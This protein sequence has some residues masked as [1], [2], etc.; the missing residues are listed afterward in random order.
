MS[1]ELSQ[2]AQ[3]V[4]DACMNASCEK[5][6]KTWVAAALCAAACHIYDELYYGRL[7]KER[8]LAIA[9]ELDGNYPEKPDSSIDGNSKDKLTSYHL[10]PISF[11]DRLPGS[12]DCDNE[13]CVWVWDNFNRQWDFAYI[14][15]RPKAQFPYCTHWLPYYALP[16]PVKG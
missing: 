12:E 8:L 6:R 1:K 3:A 7:F 5:P 10:I 11:D 14:R 9:A 13:G 15:T 16:I 4:L 2:S